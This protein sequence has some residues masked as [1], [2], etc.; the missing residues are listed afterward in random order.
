M[1]ASLQSGLA[2]VLPPTEGLQ[3][4]LRADAGVNVTNNGYVTDWLDQSGRGRDFS[5]I[6]EGETNAPQLNDSGISGKPTVSFDGAVQLFR[7]D[8]DV[9][10]FASKE[11]DVFMVMKPAGAEGF[12]S[13]QL[14][15]PD[16]KSARF[17]VQLFN[18]GSWFFDYGN[19]NAEGGRISGQAPEGWIGTTHILELR[20]EDSGDGTILVDSIP[21]G[22]GS[23]SGGLAETKAG[24]LALM[25]A[26]DIAEILIYNRALSESERKLLYDYLK[27]KYSL[28]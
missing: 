26:G 28:K 25:G 22:L 3:L 24:R 16:D 11:V 21:V 13:L 8:P 14:Q 19:I 1:G 12:T 6:N 23:F 10:F 20:R 5:W 18:E 15:M 17:S 9:N 7:N 2:E 4:W 27:E